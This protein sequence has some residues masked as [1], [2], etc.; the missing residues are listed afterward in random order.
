MSSFTDQLIQR[1]SGQS[2]LV[3]PRQ[4]SLFEPSEPR[5][6][7]SDWGMEK[8][9]HNFS[10]QP[11]KEYRPDGTNERSLNFFKPMSVTPEQGQ[12]SKFTGLPPEGTAPVFS[13]TQ[14][15]NTFEALDLK[16]PDNYGKVKLEI[17]P[18]AEKSTV[19]PA[20]PLIMSGNETRNASIASPNHISPREPER[21]W[22]NELKTAANTWLQPEAK[23]V[24]RVS[25]GRLEVRATPKTQIAPAKSSP[26]PK[27]RMSL[28]DYLN[29]Q[30]NTGK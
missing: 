5:A 30:K 6:G 23:P 21:D 1:H 25:I 24:V 28:E 3:K 14:D 15:N 29:K 2:E 9:E 27:P 19:V 16:S 26:P 7:Q 11:N 22:L 20:E 18:L 13:I 17:Q 8:E 4:R 12:E 10:A